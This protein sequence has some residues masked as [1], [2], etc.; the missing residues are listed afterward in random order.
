MSRSVGGIRLAGVLVT[1]LLLLAF[2]YMSDSAEEEARPERGGTLIF[3]I[4]TEPSS[5]EGL[6]RDDAMA[7]T[8]ASLTQ[9]PLIRQHPATRALE[10]WLA[11]RWDVSADGRTL[12]L[13]L[14]RDLAWSDGT[15]FTADDVRFTIE[16]VLDASV[17][18]PFAARFTTGSGAA[19]VVTPHAWSAIVRMPA[20]A[21]GGALAAVVDLPIHPAHALREARAAGRLHTAWGPGAAAAAFAGMGPFALQ[22][23]EPGRLVLERNARYWRADEAGEPLPYLD[24]VVLQVR[25]DGRAHL[26]E[27]QSDGADVLADPLPIEEYPEARRAERGGAVALLERGVATRPLAFWFCLSP[28]RDRDPRWAFVRQ[29]EFRRALSHAVDREQFAQ[30]VFFG[31][32]VPVWGVVTPGSPRYFNPNVPRYP[33]DAGAVR[34]LMAQ[35]GLQDRDGNGVLDHAS[36]ATARFEAIAPEGGRMQEAARAL[37]RSLAA[38]GVD[39]EMRFLPEAGLQA[40]LATCEYEMAFAPAPA[41]VLGSGVNLEFWLSSGAAHVWHPRQGR[42][43]TDWEAGIDALMVQHAGASGEARRELFHEA[44]RIL[45]EQLPLIA[46]AAPREYLVHHPRVRNL[47]AASGRPLLWNAD[48]IHVA[49]PRFVAAR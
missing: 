19:E 42:P 27:I 49:E 2:L 6:T 28:Q 35:A 15:P 7:A 36:G 10:P 41:G 21:A 4:A 47:D 24:R 40:R 13:T 1:G 46:L 43:A 33:P 45:G 22:S 8:I 32:A 17:Q 31:Q 9:A 20:D 12:T 34:E 14:R 38:A 3:S 18:S 48:S 23:R 29:A 30:T 37:T 16:T 44:Q 11:E 39:V 5:L 26:A 25:R